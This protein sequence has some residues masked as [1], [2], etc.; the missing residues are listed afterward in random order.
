M[1]INSEKHGEFKVAKLK[2]FS[3]YLIIPSLI[4]TNN[5]KKLML[6]QSPYRDYKKYINKGFFKPG[7]NLL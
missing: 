2:T 5:L 4:V 3:S 1:H 6:K 7:V